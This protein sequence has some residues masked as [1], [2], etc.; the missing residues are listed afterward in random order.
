MLLRCESLEPP[1][2]QLGQARSSIPGFIAQ[3]FCPQLPQFLPWVQR[4]KALNLCATSCRCTM[5][6]IPH[7]AQTGEHASDEYSHASEVS[8]SQRLGV[9][10][11]GP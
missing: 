6:A 10:R 5:R 11:S 7:P 3:T 9:A 2:S 8:G 1:M 4:E